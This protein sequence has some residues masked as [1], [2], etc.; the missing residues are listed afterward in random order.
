MKKIQVIDNFL[1]ENFFLECQEYSKDRWNSGDCC[2]RTNFPWQQVIVKDSYPILYTIDTEG[3]IF[4]KMKQHMVSNHGLILTKIMFY[5]FTQG[6]HIPWHDDGHTSASCTVYLNENWD[7]H[8]GGAFLYEEG[9]EIKAIYPKRNRGVIQQGNA[10][11]TVVPT[12]RSSD[13]RASIQMFIL[14]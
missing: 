9:D 7:I 12:T 2:L 3:Q 1:N 8:H 14:K 11:H 13:I 4:E 5:Y 6:A 10:R